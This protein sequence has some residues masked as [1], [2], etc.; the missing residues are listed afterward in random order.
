MTIGRTRMK[1]LRVARAYL[2]MY[3]EELVAVVDVHVS[4]RGVG[5]GPCSRGTINIP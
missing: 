3:S 2:G 4:A 5:Q 1:D